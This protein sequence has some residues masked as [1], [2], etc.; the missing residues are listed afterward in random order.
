MIPLSDDQAFD[1]PYQTSLRGGRPYESSVA[2]SA[3]SSQ[4]SVFS[5]PLSAQSSIASSVSDDFP[6]SQDDLRDRLCTQAQFQHQSKLDLVDSRPS[7]AAIT[8]ASAEQ[9]HH[10]RRTSFARNQRPPPL[11]RQ[12]ERKISFVDNLVGKHETPAQIS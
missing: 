2:S 8:S 9:K 6:R 3:L 4:F 7:Y 5:D 12:C 1:G 10:P 11:V